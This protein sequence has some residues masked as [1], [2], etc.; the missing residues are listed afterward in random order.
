MQSYET[1]QTSLI[2]LPSDDEECTGAI[3]SNLMIETPS[4]A[5]IVEGDS[6][7]KLNDVDVMSVEFDKILAMCRDAGEDGGSIVL[8]FVG[9]PTPPPTST[10]PNKDLG[11]RASD[12]A[13]SFSTAFNSWGRNL[14]VSMDK[15]VTAAPRKKSGGEGGGGANRRATVGAKRQRK[16]CTAFLYN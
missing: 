14:K 7:Y 3:L 5:G 12:V 2:L 9:P 1:L 6:L 4:D 16:H 10:S 15:A 11:R 13:S 8:E